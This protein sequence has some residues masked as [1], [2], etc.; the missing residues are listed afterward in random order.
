MISKKR[1]RKLQRKVKAG[2]VVFKEKPSW[3][4]DDKECYNHHCRRK[5][6]MVATCGINFIPSCG[7][8]ECI[9]MAA[10]A[11]QNI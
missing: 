6:V 9:K 10:W 4:A 8:R 3:M 11:A 7:N 5:V 1:L 2:E